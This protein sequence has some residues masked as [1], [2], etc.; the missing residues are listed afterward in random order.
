[1]LRSAT[2]P[3]VVILTGL[4]ALMTVAG[5]VALLAGRGSRS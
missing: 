4:G 1:V 5:V 3:A 2:L